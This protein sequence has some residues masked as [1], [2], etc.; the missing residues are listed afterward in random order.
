MLYSLKSKYRIFLITR[1]DN[2]EN[3]QFKAAKACFAKFIDDG[4][5]KPHRIMFFTTEKGKEAMVR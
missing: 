2:E 5:V 4:V 3:E 1:V